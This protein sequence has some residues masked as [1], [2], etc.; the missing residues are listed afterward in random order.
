M[1]LKNAS[2]FLFIF[3]SINLKI[4]AQKE[5]QLWLTGTNF[6]ESTPTSPDTGVFKNFGLTIT[7]FGYAP[8]KTSRVAKG[9][10]LVWAMANYCDTNG[11]LVLYT[12]GSKLFNANHELIENGD[13]LNYSLFWDINPGGFY[14]E[15][16]I[17]TNPQSNLLI[18]NPYNYNQYYLFAIQYDWGNN[19]PEGNALPKLRYSLVDM[20]LNNGKGKVIVKEKTLYQGN[21]CENIMACKKANGKDW[22]II[23]RANDNTNCFYRVSLDSS[24]VK[25]YADRNCIGYNLYSLLNYDS[26]DHRT[27]ACFSPNGKYMAHTSHR[28]TELFNFDRCTG[29]FTTV[30]YHNTPFDDTLYNLL[31]FIGSGVSFSPNS[32]FFYTTYQN[33]IYQYETKDADFAVTKQRVAYSN[34]L[35]IDSVPVQYFTAQLAPDGKIYIGHAAASPKTLHVIDSPN[36]KGLRCTLRPNGMKLLTVTGGV[37]YYPNYALGADSTSCYRTGIG[38]IAPDDYSLY[39]NPA[40][41]KLYLT[42]PDTKQLNYTIYDIVGKNCRA[43]KASKEIDVSGLENGLYYLQLSSDNLSQQTMKFEVRR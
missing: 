6:K 12:N 24:G 25:T 2:Y 1:M 16:I 30:Q 17:G 32:Q 26:I 36:L 21:F 31:R 7:D 13:S 39:P 35:Y 20:S 33:R 27:F 15:Y 29:K 5:T 43:G 19:S 9:L 8:P 22:W 10:S 34:I 4:Y 40:S 23:A 28:G 37:P 11:K 41:D 18:R 38:D 42:Y 14:S 3:L